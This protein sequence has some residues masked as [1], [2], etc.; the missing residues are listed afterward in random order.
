ME[1]I[2]LAEII[3]VTISSEISVYYSGFKGSYA[4]LADSCLRKNTLPGL[5]EKGIISHAVVNN[6]GLLLGLK[7]GLSE[8]EI[9]E[10]MDIALKNTGT[11]PTVDDQA[12]F[13][14]IVEGK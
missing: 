12:E 1:V 11:F 10:I 13:N 6:Q 4:T 14:V 5:Y 3:R 8:N 9:I 7:A 2:F